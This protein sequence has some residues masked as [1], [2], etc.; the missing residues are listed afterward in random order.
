MAS[1]IRPHITRLHVGSIRNA[2]S[3]AAPGPFTI[4]M[5][6]PESRD[7]KTIVFDTVQDFHAEFR[8]WCFVDT[9]TRRAYN[10]SILGHSRV[11]PDVVYEATHLFFAA[12]QEGSHHHQIADKAFEEKS[13][14][15]MERHL[16]VSDGI[17]RFKAKD[18]SRPDGWRYLT[19]EKDVVE[20]DGLWQGIDGRVYCL[21]VKHF[22]DPVS[23]QY[24]FRI[25]SGLET[26][27]YR[28][29]LPKF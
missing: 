12:R 27:H 24:F 19:A 8:E 10:G 28:T 21:E 23:S 4:T 13:I 26:Y 18:P 2:R 3:K 6:T 25:L 22:V 15:A 17:T 29:K 11:N 1:S 14:K 16:G 7:A 9:Q 5:V 20:W